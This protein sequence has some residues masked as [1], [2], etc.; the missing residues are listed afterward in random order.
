MVGLRTTV[1]RPRRAGRAPGATDVPLLSGSGLSLRK[2]TIVF[3]DTDADE[4]AGSAGL[5]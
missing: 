4:L 5:D 3:D 1:G 2:G